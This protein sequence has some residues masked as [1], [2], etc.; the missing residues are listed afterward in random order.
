MK[1]SMLATPLLLLAS[2]ISAAKGPGIEVQAGRSFYAAN[3]GTQATSGRVAYLTREDEMTGVR[4]VAA[5][6]YERG[7]DRA[8]IQRV[9]LDLGLRGRVLGP[10]YL[11]LGGAPSYIHA[12]GGPGD[13]ADEVF[14]AGYAE[15]G[16]E[17]SLSEHLT[18]GLS[19][20]H[21]FGASVALGD[22]PNENLNTGTLAATVGWGF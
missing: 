14:M 12:S 11:G 19:Y 5:I 15:V 1:Y 20:R 10:I 4:G 2:C 13:T 7:S 21:T 6:S 9:E 3:S 16:A 8:T 17:W 18:A 22:G